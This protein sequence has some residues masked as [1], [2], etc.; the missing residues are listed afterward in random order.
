ML[1]VGGFIPLSTT[2][3]PD[4]LAAVVFVQGCPWRCHYCHNP[5]LQPRDVTGSWSW[6]GVLDKLHHRQ[7]LLDGIVFSG[8][9]PTLDSYLHQAIQDVKALGFQVGLHTAGIYPDRL[10]AL[11][12]HLD[13]IGLDIKTDFAHYERVTDVPRSGHP[14]WR[15]LMSVLRSGKA[16]EIRTTYHPNLHAAEDLQRLAESLSQLGVERWVIQGFRPTD[17]TPQH[18]GH[19]EQALPPA[20]LTQLMHSGVRIQLR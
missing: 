10:Q 12:P 3:W 5:A 6:S 20:W 17:D 13:W 15:S 1:D 14:A 2:D 8:G 4:H 16:Y 19:Q 11:L 18:L 7:G 9:E